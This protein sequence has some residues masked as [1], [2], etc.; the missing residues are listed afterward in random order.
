MTMRAIRTHTHPIRS[1]SMGAL[2]IIAFIASNSNSY[3]FGTVIAL[4]DVINSKS[5]LLKGGSL[6]FTICVLPAPTSNL[7]IETRFL[8]ATRQKY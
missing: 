3:K 5:G 6:S 7:S 1:T 8:L 2:S 4:A